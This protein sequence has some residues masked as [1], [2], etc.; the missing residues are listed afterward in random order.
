QTKQRYYQALFSAAKRDERVEL[1]RLDVRKGEM[2]GM[3]RDEIEPEFTFEGKFTR[4]ELEARVLKG[5]RY[6][7]N[8]RIK[9]F[10]TRGLSINQL[11]GYMDSL[12]STENFIP[13]L[14]IIDY[15]KIMK[16]DGADYRIKLGQTME[17]IR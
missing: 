3:S 7:N 6:V 5:S 1:T 10:P 17:D 4:N 13:D 14:L 11:R 15:P 9:R 12:E 16:I 8:L 2:V